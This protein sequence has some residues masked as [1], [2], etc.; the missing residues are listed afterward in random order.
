MIYF[1]SNTKASPLFT[2]QD[3][4]EEPQISSAHPMAKLVRALMKSQHID[5]MMLENA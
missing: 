4:T 5:T 3:W 2:N 1:L